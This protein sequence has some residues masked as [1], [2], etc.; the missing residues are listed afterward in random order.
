LNQQR[1]L[2]KLGTLTQSTLGQNRGQT[3]QAPVKRGYSASGYQP[4]YPSV[5]KPSYQ[6]WSNPEDHGSW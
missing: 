4:G 3:Q 1:T 2:N 5:S 6:G